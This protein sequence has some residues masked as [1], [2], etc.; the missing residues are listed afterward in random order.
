MKFG[1]RSGPNDFPEETGLC[2]HTVST[3]D[4]KHPSNNAAIPPLLD[5]ARRCAEGAKVAP[6][7]RVDIKRK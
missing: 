2:I 6:M 5:A 4:S 1:W 7:V 3:R